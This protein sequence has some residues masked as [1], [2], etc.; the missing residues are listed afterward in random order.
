MKDLGV[1]FDWDGILVDSAALHVASW[2]KLAQELGRALPADLR[3][4]SLGLKTEA[5]ISDLLGWAQ[6]PAEARRLSFRKEVLFRELV[7]HDGISPQPGVLPL[8]RNLRR[9]GVPCA[10]GSSAPA[11]NIEVGLDALDAW[12][13]F[14]AVAAGDEVERGKPAP[15]IF[16]KAAQQIGVPPANCVVFE[17]A[18]AGVEAGHAAGM[19]VVAVL[20][21]NGRE[22][23]AKADRIVNSFEEIVDADPATW[24]DLVPA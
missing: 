23:L 4:G 18:P 15:D 14:A 2:E 1:I 19:K 9:L 11:L 22:Q 17:D 24:F 7:R 3:I 5:V 13:L 8:V 6:D 10:I 20:T 21:T 12:S 16:L